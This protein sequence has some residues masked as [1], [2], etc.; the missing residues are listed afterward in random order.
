[1][2]LTKSI[3]PQKRAVA[4]ERKA[5][6]LDQETLEVS[7]PAAGA[8]PPATEP[9]HP[10][11]R[12][13]PKSQSV[14]PKSLSESEIEVLYIEHRPLLLFVGCRKFQLDQGEAENLIHEVFLSFLQTQ[15]RI[16]NV[17]AWLVAAMCNASRHYWRSVGRVEPL[18]DDYDNQSDPSSH[19]LPDP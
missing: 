7:A 8:T 13:A 14:D 9:P 1:M 12:T 6:V 2:G 17:R 16:E 3:N 5:S 10:Q 18:P 15:T 11:R 4:N 19:S